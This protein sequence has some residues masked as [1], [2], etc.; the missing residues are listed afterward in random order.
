MSTVKSL[1]YIVINTKKREMTIPESSKRTLYAYIYGIIRNQGCTLIRMNG[2]GNHI[3]MLLDLSTELS[4]SQFM[5][6]MK[7]SSSIWLK[8]HP[9]SFPAIKGWGKEYY[10]FSVGVAQKDA[11]V[12]YIKNQETHHRA[13]A[14]DEEMQVIT[15]ENECECYYYD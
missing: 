1:Y 2:I 12:A 14:Y 13:M 8:S 15:S 3:H 5:R 10:A 7:R 6:E 4:L 11:V 9:E